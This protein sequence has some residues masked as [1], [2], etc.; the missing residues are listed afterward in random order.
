MGDREIAKTAPV[1]YVKF[2]ESIGI[3]TVKV[4]TEAELIDV[5]KRISENRDKRLMV[6]VVQHKQLEVSQ[7]LQDF[8]ASVGAHKQKK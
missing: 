5:F 6:H 4:E 7:T 8:M 2:G 3:D 1:D